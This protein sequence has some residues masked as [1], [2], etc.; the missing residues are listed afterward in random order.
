MAK[1]I[2]A[3]WK[4][5]PKSISEAV[6]LAKASDFENVVIAPPYPY[7][8]KVGRII[9]KAFLGAQD[10]FWEDG[11]SY[12]G[13][14]SISQLKDLKVKYVIIGHSERREHL[15]ETD[16]VINKKIRLAL[17]RGFKVVLCVGESLKVRRQGALASQRHVLKQ[18]TQGLRGINS[19]KPNLIIAYEPIWAIGTGKSDSPGEATAII[20]SMRKKLFLKHGIQRR[21]EIKFLYGGSINARNAFGFLN[22]QG[23]DG[24]LVGGASLSPQSFKTIIKARDSI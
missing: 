22:R 1:L 16:E 10:V 24:A 17:S 6:K 12:T 21:G 4:S 3:N 9:K 18:L 13:E 20:S 2:V 8:E 14:V 5:N 7:L 11:G 15:G 19:I 23:I